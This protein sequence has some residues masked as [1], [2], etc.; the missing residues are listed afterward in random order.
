LTIQIRFSKWIEIPIQI[1]LFLE[2]D[3]GQQIL[4]GQSWNPQYVDISYQLTPY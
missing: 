3:I 2:K 1:Q 4:N